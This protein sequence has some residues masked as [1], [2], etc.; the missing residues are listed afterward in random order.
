M[1]AT[2]LNQQQARVVASLGQLRQLQAGFAGPAAAA[3]AVARLDKCC[4]WVDAEQ[5][6]AAAIQ[7]P[8]RLKLDRTALGMFDLNRV[9]TLELGY[10]WDEWDGAA[11]DLLCRQLSRCAQLRSLHLA[12]APSKHVLQAI[13]ALP[14]LQHLCLFSELAG[15]EAAPTW[16]ALAAGC[17]QLRQLTLW[18]IS[19]L[20][21]QMLAA[22]MAGLPQLRLLRLL[23]CDPELSQE[24]CQALVGR[25]GLW[26]LQVDAVVYDGTARAD[27]MIARLEERWR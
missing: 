21:E 1:A 16:D 26:E 10:G 3:A 19:P 9:H 13:A 5:G 11:A 6:S 12:G 17:S 25:L 27:W 18:D 24:R 2:R 23:G 8:G 4:M 7:A 14:Q 22:L 15:S 20:S